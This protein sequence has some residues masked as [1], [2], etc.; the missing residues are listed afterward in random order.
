MNFKI[1]RDA[2]KTL[3]QFLSVDN[4]SIQVFMCFLKE[5]ECSVSN[6]L[7]LCSIRVLDGKRLLD[8]IM[9]LLETKWWLF[10]FC[11]RAV[12]EIFLW[13]FHN[14][15]NALILTKHFCCCSASAWCGY[16]L[17]GTIIRLLNIKFRPLKICFRAF[18]VVISFA[19]RQER[20]TGFDE[21]FFPCSMH[22][23]RRVI[24]YLEFSWVVF[25]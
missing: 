18:L 3:S 13:A 14:N 23:W 4:A 9:H 21:T 19:Y 15:T 20:C 17:F 24:S 7:F 11:F 16:R 12:S 2:K 6:E 5:K 10:K 8:T 22:V 25:L 1:L